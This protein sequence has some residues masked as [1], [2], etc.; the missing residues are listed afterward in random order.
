MKFLH[1]LALAAMVMTLPAFAHAEK[2]DKAGCSY[3]GIKLQ[4]RVQFVNSFPDI[5]VKIDN[6]F[7]DLKVKT[8]E[9][10]PDSCGKWK[11]VQSFPDFKVQ[12]VQSFPDFTISMDSSW[13]GVR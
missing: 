4:G 8:V 7:P 9:S 3:K 6:S 5:K 13:P 11:V 2:I 1:H 10:F 12:M